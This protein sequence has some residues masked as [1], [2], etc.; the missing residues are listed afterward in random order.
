MGQAM[1]QAPEGIFKPINYEMN[2]LV[3]TPL[4]GWKVERGEHKAWLHEVG[5][6]Q[7]KF[8]NVEFF[9]ALEVDSRGI[10]EYGSFIDELGSH[11]IAYWTYMINDM[12]PN[13]SSKNRWIRIETGRNLIRE[14]AQRKCKLGGLNWGEA[15]DR[16]GAITYDAILYIDSD[17]Q[18]TL[19]MVEKLVE[20]NHHMVGIDVPIYCLSGKLINENPRIEEHWNTA[21]VLLINSPFFYDL[22]WYHNSYL[23]LS[24]DPTL[25]HLAERLYGQTWVR[26]D[27]KA[28]HPHVKE[29]EARGIPNRQYS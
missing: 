18:L 26:K 17:V 1:E 14:Y 21:G 7:E 23:N 13:V 15:V 12:D 3:G 19:E 11:R 10:A 5:K 4:V 8:P 27:V 6:I 9:A 16:T 29:V 20:V 2:L 28:H 25:Q 24:E 22:P